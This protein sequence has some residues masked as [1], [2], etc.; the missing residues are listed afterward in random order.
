MTRERVKYY[1]KRQVIDMS[2]VGESDYGDKVLVCVPKF[3]WDVARAFLSDQGLW[4][5]TYS[6]EYHDS[7]YET[8]SSEEF[9]LID[10]SISDFL[11]GDD[12]SCDLVEAMEGLE[13][14]L[15]RLVAKSCCGPAGGGSGGA[16]AT[17]GPASEFEDDG[18]TPP[19]EF[20]TYSEW[21]AWKC[22]VAKL[23]YDEMTNDLD[24]VKGIAVS[25]ISAIVLSAV[26]LTPIPFDDIAVLVGVIIAWGVEE[27]VD[28]LIDEVLT[29]LGADE[30]TIVCAL[31]NSLSVPGAES[32]LNDWANSSLTDLAGFLLSFFV[33][34]DS[35]NRLFEFSNLVLPS[36]DCA[37][38][39]GDDL[40]EVGET[41]QSCVGGVKTEGSFAD[42]FTME[43]RPC[44]AFG[45]Y[46]F[47]QVI[48][49]S[50]PDGSN[51]T[52]TFHDVVNPAGESF[53]VDGVDVN[54][55]Y[56]QIPRGDYV[57]GTPIDC[58]RVQLI[59]G[60]N[61]ETQNFTVEVSVELYSP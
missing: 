57:M 4:R 47:Q 51:V 12:M 10:A 48:L 49:W 2:L 20:E 17:E 61:E 32:W 13:K 18:E 60:I 42:E 26:L 59:G 44:L 9:D 24:Y 41:V 31:Y 43:S 38:C 3:A 5:T 45:S 23:I 30:E 19:E 15:A 39:V 8:P 54:G 35:L 7:Y 16:G 6:M 28:D 46:L 33:S 29:E 56:F 36:Y 37:T 21:Q 11:K 53:F 55:D 50:V 58:R 40:V 52:V 25:E 27:I 34:N 22:G 1:N 14:Q